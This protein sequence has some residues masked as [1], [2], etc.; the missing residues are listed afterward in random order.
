M[1]SGI[2]IKDIGEK[3]LFG[4][5]NSVVNQTIKTIDKGIYIKVDSPPPIKIGDFCLPW[6]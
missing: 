2:S 3:G 6:C 1:V 4:G 5:E